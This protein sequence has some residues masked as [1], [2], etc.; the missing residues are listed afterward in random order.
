MKKPPQG[1]LNGR[2]LLILGGS[3]GPLQLFP[4]PETAEFPLRFQ[5]APD[6]ATRR[7]Q[8]ENASA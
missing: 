7:F 5:G 3:G 4:P 6:R 2:K 1:R 8:P